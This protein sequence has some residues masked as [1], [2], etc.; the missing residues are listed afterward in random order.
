MPRKPEKIAQR[1]GESWRATVK[2]LAGRWE[3]ECLRDFDMQVA[4][5]I[6]EADAARYALCAWRRIKCG[7]DYGG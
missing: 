6:S 5:G 3:P 7:P 2:R 1:S 4:N